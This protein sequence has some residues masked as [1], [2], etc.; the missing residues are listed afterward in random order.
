M[1]F[2]DDYSRQCWVCTMKHKAKVSELFIERKK[3]IEKSMGRKFKIL[4]LDNGGEYISD[5]F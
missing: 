5:P 3:N 1:S 2:I 4:R